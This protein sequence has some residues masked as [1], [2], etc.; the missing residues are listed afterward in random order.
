LAVDDSRIRDRSSGGVETPQAGLAGRNARAWDRLYRDTEEC[1]WGHVPV[2]FLDHFLEDAR[3]ALR[4]GS[5]ILDLACGE[6]RNLEVLDRLTGTLIACDYSLHGLAKAAASARGASRLIR[7]VLEDLPVRDGRFSF[8]LA[9]D[10][11]E[12]LPDL[13]E[14]L[15]EMHRILEVGGCLLANVPDL[16]DGIAGTDMRMIQPHEYLYRDLFYYR[17][18]EA[19]EA[20]RRFERAGF[21]IRRQER[22]TW[23]EDA[24][25]GFREQPHRHT[26]SVFLVQRTR[27]NG[28]R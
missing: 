19:S 14:S 5:L 4:P 7:C 1:V 9:S 8:I 2:G 3:A 27:Q 16:D 15:A 6:G 18:M 25:P 13:E 23:V 17:F 28:E 10:I 22:C 20:H 24:H 11:L 12:T 21:A 26:S